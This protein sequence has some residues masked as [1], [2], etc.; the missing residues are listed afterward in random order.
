MS[1]NKIDQIYSSSNSIKDYSRSYLEY[2]A[3]VLNNISLTDIEK[4]VGVL[5]EARNKE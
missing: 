5:L 3:S 4:F 1:M 2:L